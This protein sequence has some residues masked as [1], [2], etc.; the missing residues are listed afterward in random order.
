MQATTFVKS[1]MRLCAVVGAMTGAGFAG[2]ASSSSGA[3]YVLSMSDASLPHV[4]YPD[5]RSPFEATVNLAEPEQDRIRRHLAT[6]EA[7]L[8][9]HPPAGLTDAQMKKR[10]ALLDTLRV[11]REQ[12]VFPR[13]LDFHNRLIPYFV[14]A[15]GVPCA[16]AKLVIASGHG[17]FAAE[18]RATMNNA[19]IGEIAAADA[20]LAA[21]G[22]EHG[23]TLDEAAR[24]QP[25]YGPPWLQNV[26]RIRLDSLKRPWAF[27]PDMNAVGSAALFYRDA[28][29]WKLDTAMLFSFQGFCV[30]PGGRSLRLI[31]S[32]VLG[33]NGRTY[34]QS[35]TGITACEWAPGGS[36]AWLATRQGLV[37]AR[38][39]GTSDTLAIVTFRT[40]LGSDT[41]TG[42]AV[43]SNAVWA[44]TE[45]GVYRR[46]RTG[47]DTAVTAWDSVAIWGKRVTGIKPTGTRVW[48][49]IDG[50]QNGFSTMFSTRGLRRY[51][52]T[53]WSAFVASQSSIQTPG[54]TIYALAV[55]DTGSAW[56]ATPSGFM[57]F[58]GTTTQKVADIPSGVMVHDMDGD[59][60]GFYA[61][62]SAGVYRYDGTALLFLG[63]PAVSIRPGIAG[64]RR[65]VVP[66]LR[67]LRPG[68][69]SEDGLITLQGRKTG[70]RQATG[71]Y[72]TPRVMPSRD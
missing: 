1:A 35:V 25:A 7:D 38:R 44:A 29:V 50:T 48:L 59:A 69:S 13:N 6:V 31:N 28:S 15:A 20:R 55:R 23:I 12:G 18:V 56:V 36:E 54:D 47:A 51:N 63:Q 5:P 17:T 57:S 68:E 8:R 52:G 66:Q 72:I 27:G 45:R 42:V 58:N 61:A 3:S 26:L 62:T 22:V 60:T 30:A 32:N 53:G 24:V 19:Y 46:G 2:A 14:D 34:S 11:Y 40:P 4:A 39:G 71:V 65:E 9:A 41:V 37:R 10:L 21:W 67:M 43:T 33:W 64:N 49:G 70:D 16:M